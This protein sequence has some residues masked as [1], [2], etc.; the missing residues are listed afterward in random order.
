L[1]ALGGAASFSPLPSIKGRSMKIYEKGKMHIYCY[2]FVFF[3]KC[4]GKAF[5]QFSSFLKDFLS[6]CT[7]SACGVFC[8]IILRYSS[9]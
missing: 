9:R 5:M 4:L 6:A 2:N 3:A 7:I 8:G 1:T